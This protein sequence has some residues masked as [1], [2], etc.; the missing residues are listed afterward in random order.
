MKLEIGNT[1]ESKDSDEIATIEGLE[2]ID[3]QLPLGEV[4]VPRDG[5]EKVKVRIE[6]GEVPWYTTTMTLRD[7]NENYERRRRPDLPA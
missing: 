2:V 3:K 4:V 5:D 6:R 1:W 7:L